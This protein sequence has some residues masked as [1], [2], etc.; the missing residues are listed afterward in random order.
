MMLRAELRWSLQGTAFPTLL[1]VAVALNA[2]S[3]YGTVQGLPADP[4]SSEVS[5]QSTTVT[6]VALGFGGSLFSMIFGALTATRD[7]GN[8]AIIR[9]AFLARGSERLLAH[10]AAVMSVPLIAIAIA[11]AAT[12][13]VM[14]AI[15]LPLRGYQFAWSDKALVVVLGVSFS[16]FAMGQIG[17]LVGWLFRNTVVTL[18]ALVGYTLVAETLIVS[19]L[20]QVGIYLPGGAIA[21][22]TYDTSVTELILPV[23]AG[24]ALLVGWVTVLGVANVFR[25]RRT[26]LA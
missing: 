22:I 4:P 13:V 11:S 20:P 18:I 9:R 24:Y 25:L 7:F 10:R 16:V 6:L 21:S 1:F 23:P 12:P 14:A 15:A 5:M 8:S 3:V 19:L 26:D 17:H 2:L